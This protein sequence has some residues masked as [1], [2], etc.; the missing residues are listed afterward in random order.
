MSSAREGSRARRAV[1]VCLAVA[2]TGCGEGAPRPPLFEAPD[3]GSVAL[4]AGPPSDAGGGGGCALTTPLSSR[5]GARTGQRVTLASEARDAADIVVDD[6]WVYWV[7]HR[8][9]TIHRVARDGTG[10]VTLASDEL[11]PDGLAL[12]EGY[13]YWLSGDF[14]HAALRRMPAAGGEVVSLGRARRITI[15][16]SAR[17]RVA[18]D[19]RY[20]YWPDVG[21]DPFTDG[22]IYR[23]PK[24]GGAPEAVV[25]GIVAPASVVVDRCN[26]YWLAVGPL[27]AT[28]SALYRGELATAPVEGGPTRVLAAEQYNVG[29]LVVDERYVYWSVSGRDVEDGTIQR[30]AKSGG[31]PTTLVDRQFI[32]LALAIDD[33]SLYT[34]EDGLVAIPL[35]GGAPTTL[36]PRL[37]FSG[38]SGVS[39]DARGVYFAGSVGGAWALNFLPFAP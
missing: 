15:F 35:S 30:V 28:G 18:F 12:D 17:H 25:S 4:D 37:S 34:L 2:A 39:V 22:S 10:A 38:S 8:A 11:H 33:R 21:D 9:G 3:A 6:A 5:A 32:G 31:A 36:V 29:D 14:D 27:V 1:A 16:Q 20:V 13:L 23:L 19:A 24:S 7:D 26:L